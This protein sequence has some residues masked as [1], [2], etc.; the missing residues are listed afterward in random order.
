[1]IVFLLIFSAIVTILL[2]VILYAG[3]KEKAYDPREKNEPL[4]WWLMF[5]LFSMGGT[6]IGFCIALLS[7]C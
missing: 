3:A 2:G 4:A 5:L 1:M 6:A 7:K